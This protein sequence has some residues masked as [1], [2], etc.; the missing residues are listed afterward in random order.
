[1]KE[2]ICGKDND[3]NDYAEALMAI[4]VDDSL[5]RLGLY[6]SQSIYVSYRAGLGFSFIVV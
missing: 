5:K 2:V 1:M 4:T 3:R 6:L